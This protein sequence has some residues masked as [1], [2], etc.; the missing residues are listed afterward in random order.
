ML[1]RQNPKGSFMRTNNKGRIFFK[2]FL[3]L[4]FCIIPILCHLF[5][6]YVL[7]IAFENASCNID[8]FFVGIKLKVQD[9][10]YWWHY[11][12]SFIGT[13]VYFLFF[14]LKNKNHVTLF[15]NFLIFLLLFFLAHDIATKHSVDSISKLVTF[16]FNAISL[17]IYI[18][19]FLLILIL[20][21]LDF[22]QIFHLV[23]FFV[24]SNIVHVLSFLIYIHFSRF[25]YGA[26][27]VFLFVFMNIFPI[28]LVNSWCI[29]FFLRL[30][31]K[32]ELEDALN[33]SSPSSHRRI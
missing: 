32:M 23:Y 18:N 7:T 27:S 6:S 10:N 24:I 11:V 19:F 5:L 29:C 9:Q 28:I 21:S 20:K 26:I 15:F 1:Y 33:F 2:I 12:F 17:Y 3:S 30:S 13:L 4:S 22:Y 14:R 31:R 8:H 25:L 16:F